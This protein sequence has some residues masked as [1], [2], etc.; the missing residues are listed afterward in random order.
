MGNFKKKKFPCTTISFFFFYHSVEQTTFN[1]VT[2][3]RF[4]IS[5]NSPLN[6]GLQC[7]IVVRTLH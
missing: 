1:I 2:R 3:L 7:L 6:L 4:V 5:C